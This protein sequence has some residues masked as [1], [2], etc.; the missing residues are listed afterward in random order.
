[1]P[2]FTQDGC[3]IWAVRNDHSKSGW[4]I[5]E[6]SGS[7]VTTLQSLEPNACPSG[8]L[9]WQSSRGYEVKDDGWILGSTRKRLLWLPH[10][11]RSGERDRRW[12]GRFLGLLH[13]LPEMII[14]EFLD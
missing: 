14:L 1:M 4:K 2:W 5:V 13:E 7:G 3:E 9:P 12:G 8:A 11:W 6:D 10:D